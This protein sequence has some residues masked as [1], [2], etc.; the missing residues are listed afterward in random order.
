M[1][2]FLNGQVKDLPVSTADHLSGN[3]YVTCTDFD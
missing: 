1:P 2:S 3:W